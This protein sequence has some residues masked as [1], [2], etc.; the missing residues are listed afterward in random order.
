[1]EGKKGKGKLGGIM[2]G[3][4]RNR[5]NGSEEM[6]KKKGRKWKRRNRSKEMVAKKALRRNGSEE[7]DKRKLIKETKRRNVRI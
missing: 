1:M 4:S 3:N 7:V 2:E 5:S 6:G